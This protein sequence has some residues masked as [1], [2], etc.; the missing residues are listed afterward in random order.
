MNVHFLDSYEKAKNYCRIRHPTVLNVR[1][2]NYNADN[3][4]DLDEEDIE[5]IQEILD[6]SDDDDDDD[7][8]EILF[9][10][11]NEFPMPMKPTRKEN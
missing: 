4:F 8:V 1:D 10:N 6:E 11:E 5:R 2:D 3:L 7:D 9:D